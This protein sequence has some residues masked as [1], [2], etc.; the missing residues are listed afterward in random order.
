MSIDRLT[1][2]DRLMLGASTRWPQDIG[3]LAI[4]DGGPLLDADGQFRI[5]AVRDAIQGRLH[6]V[7]RFR[8]V[9]E[10]PGRGLGG[11]L[12][13]DAPTFDLSQH[14]RELPLEPRAGEPELLAAVEHLQRQ[15]LDP[16]RPLW[17][18]WFLTGLSGR[19]VGLFVRIHHT[20]ADGMAAMTTIATFLD[21]TPGAP[22]IAPA[23]PWR[24]SPWPSARALLADNLGRRLRALGRTV[25]VLAGPRPTVRRLRA[26]WP[27]IRELLAEEPATKT[28]LDRMVGP[29]RRLALIRTGLDAVREVGRA[30][31]ATVNDVLLA[32]TAG[33]LRTL[34]QSRGEAVDDTTV[35]IYVPVSLRRR[36]RGVQQGN[37]IAEM[38]VPIHL[39]EAD[40]SR[41]FEQIASETTERKARTRT[42][43]G[44]LMVGGGIGRRL[45]L[46][47]VMRQRVNVTSASIPGPRVPLFLAG[48]RVLEVF[49]VL[50]LIAN[51]P[52]GIGALSYAGALTIGIAADREV[53]PDLDVLT[54]A[55]RDELRGLGVPTYQGFEGAAESGLAPATASAPARRG[56]GARR[57]LRVSQ[58]TSST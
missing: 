8:Q 54:T 24:S 3:A 50:P 4:L 41:R 36:L 15:R 6:L 20:I 1:A 25:S 12:W 16:S 46:L 19:R 43:L 51:E 31:D 53:Y 56:R 14:V 9:I 32:A 30:H 26:A 49:P 45:L 38:A 2:L 35:R 18:M 11:P 13:V 21:P 52:L 34:L 47:A 29:D 39:G 5:D 22:A 55:M 23:P 7:P 40:P 48:A 58:P 17:Q 44:A 33:G 27:A 28:S 42:N 37:M 10:V 57:P